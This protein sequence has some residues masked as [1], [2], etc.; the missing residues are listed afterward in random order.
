MDA[1]HEKRYEVDGEA[2]VM[3]G[4]SGKVSSLLRGRIL[5]LSSSGCYIQTLASVTVRRDAPVHVE[6]WVNG[7]FFRVRAASKFART[8]VGLGVNFIDMDSMTRERLD[9]A[10]L[11][12]RSKVAEDSSDGSRGLSRK[13]AG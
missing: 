10:L 5:D 2:E 1:R 9:Q 13:K 11:H 8:K 12:I 4:S 6:F 3:V 7:E